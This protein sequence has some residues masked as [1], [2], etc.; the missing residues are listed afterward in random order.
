MIRLYQRAQAFDGDETHPDYPDYL[1][2]SSRLH[3]LLG[4]KP[5]QV[6]VVDLDALDLDCPDLESDPHGLSDYI[7][8]VRLRRELDAKAFKS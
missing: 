2:A 8:A 1:D 7:G 4:R 5:W 6:N 3:R